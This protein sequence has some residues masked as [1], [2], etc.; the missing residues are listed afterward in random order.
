M[1]REG[2]QSAAYAAQAKKEKINILLYACLKGVRTSK[3]NKVEAKYIILIT[4]VP[5]H[6]K[7]Y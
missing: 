5:H 3:Q 7:Q 2:K 4:H 6:F 1:L